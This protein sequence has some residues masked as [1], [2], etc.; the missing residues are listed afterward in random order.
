[1]GTRWIIVTTCLGSAVLAAAGGC[2]TTGAGAASSRLTASDIVETADTLRASLAVSPWL[3]GRTPDSPK[4]R[5]GLSPAENR[6]N[7]R[8][9]ESDRWALTSLVVNDPSVQQLLAE[10]NVDLYLPEETEATL[11]RRI[12]A[13]RARTKPIANRRSVQSSACRARFRRTCSAR[14]SGRSRGRVRRTR[15]RPATN[16]STCTS[17]TTA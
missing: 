10:R 14:R 5:L 4:F 9:A 15:D 6:S 12:G 17:S 8:L 2:A 16:G 11:E 13:C 1:V 3:A 7:D